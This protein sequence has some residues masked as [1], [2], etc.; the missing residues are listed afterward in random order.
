LLVQGCETSTLSE[1]AIDENAITPD[2]VTY[3][4]TAQGILNTSCVECHN[5]NN[6]T[7]GVRLDNF[8]SA[9]DVAES[10][11]ML[12]RMTSTTNPMPPAGNLPAPIIQNI[13]DWIDDGIL[14][15]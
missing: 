10:G 13:R 6:A 9:S 1:L 4:N 8:E 11:R 14:E 15:N 7:G 12:I 3:E 2:V 5:L